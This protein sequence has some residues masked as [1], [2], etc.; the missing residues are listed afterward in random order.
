MIKVKEQYLK[1]F[2]CVLNWIKYIISEY[3]EPLTVR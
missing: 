2:K 1:L 3:S